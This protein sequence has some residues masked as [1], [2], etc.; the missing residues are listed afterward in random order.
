V[1]WFF[2]DF[3]QTEHIEYE[4]REMLKPH[5]GNHKKGADLT[6]LHSSQEVDIKA[7]NKSFHTR[8]LIREDQFQAHK[9]DIYLGAKYID[10]KLIEFHGYSTAKDLEAV[11]PQ[12]FGYGMCRY[13][14]LNKLKS[15]EQFLASCK[16]KKVIT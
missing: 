3:L 2:A 7:A 8:I 6:L 16:E 14:L 5:A 10:D 4:A 15:M 13:M 1:S 11:P 12:D 9:H